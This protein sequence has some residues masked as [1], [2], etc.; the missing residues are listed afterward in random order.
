MGLCTGYAFV[1]DG[2]L[3]KADWLQPF[4]EENPSP[5]RYSW[6]HTEEIV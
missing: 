4:L 2:S 3:L 6:P 5:Y 1:H